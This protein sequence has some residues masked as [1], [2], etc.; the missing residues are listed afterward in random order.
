MYPPFN[1]VL[2]AN[3]TSIREGK[4][5]YT[6]AHIIYLR[7]SGLEEILI[8]N[9]EKDKTTTVKG[10][11]YSKGL[12]IYKKALENS[13]VHEVAERAY[14][15]LLENPRKIKQ[16]IPEDC[17]D[18][19]PTYIEYTKETMPHGVLWQIKIDSPRCKVDYIGFNTDLNIYIQEKELEIPNW[20][21]K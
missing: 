3:I 4:E 6:N 17:R 18:V 16:I 11:E 20:L 7:N 14:Y 13:K 10:L 5:F 15:I 1:K 2:Y 19:H 8:L 12:D 21:F 9:G